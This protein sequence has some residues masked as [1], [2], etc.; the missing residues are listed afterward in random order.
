MYIL[1]GLTA[2]YLGI[3]FI[4]IFYIFRG[5]ATPVLRDYINRYSDSDSRATIL[6]LRS[7]LIR[8]FFA[9][10]APLFGWFSDKYSIQQ[11]L[12]LA[13]GIFFIFSLTISF[14]IVF[15]NRKYSV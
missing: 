3:F 5:V 13:G 10:L 15:T 14:L 8:G 6:S 11:A 7:F 4:L 2:G 1:T 9:I 12:M